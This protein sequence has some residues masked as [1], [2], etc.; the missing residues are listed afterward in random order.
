MMVIS[1]KIISMEMVNTYGPTVEFTM[2]N[3]LT[4]KWKVKVHSLGVTVVD[5]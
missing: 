5:M 4:I 1:T 3:G 2:D